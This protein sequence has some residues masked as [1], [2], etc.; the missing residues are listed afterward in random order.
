MYLGTS[1]HKLTG[2]PQKEIPAFETPAGS[3]PDSLTPEELDRLRKDQ[4][5]F[6]SQRP[7]F[8]R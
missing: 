2:E 6:D 3:S 4:A 8:S 7:P 5:Q 1:A